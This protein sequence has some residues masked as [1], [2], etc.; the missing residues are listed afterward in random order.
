MLFWFTWKSVNAIWEYL[1]K[2]ADQPACLYSLISTFVIHCLDNLIPMVATGISEISRLASFCRWAGWLE[3]YLIATPEDRFSHDV[4][5][6]FSFNSVTSLRKVNFFNADF[7]MPPTSKNLTGHIGFELSVRPCVGKIS[8]KL[9]KLEAWNVI[10]WLDYLINF[11][12]NFIKYFQSYGPLQIWA[13]QTCQQDIS[14][15]ILARW[16]ELGQLIGDDG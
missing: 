16:L 8:W 5:H 2:G 12:T 3:S 13:F 15:T 11:W 6:T 9:F 14:K 10:S 4:A 1:N 7:F